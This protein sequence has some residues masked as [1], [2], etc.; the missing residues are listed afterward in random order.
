MERR[1]E[2]FSKY[3]SPFTDYHML[4]DCRRNL[5]HANPASKNT[6]KFMAII[7]YFLALLLDS[8]CPAPCCVCNQGHLGSGLR[9]Q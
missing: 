1:G 8:F 2:I 5:I 4:S 9:L 3:T 6:H 7:S